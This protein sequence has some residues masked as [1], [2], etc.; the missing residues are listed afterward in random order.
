[1][2]KEFSHEAD[3][4]RYVLRSNGELVSVVDYAISGPS[5][6]FTRTFTSPRAR[7][8]GNAAEVVEFAANDVERNTDLRIVPMCWYV[9]EWFDQH[10]EH[11]HLLTRGL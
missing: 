8:K 9:G 5:I 10:P 1:M 3:A 6:S 4:H 2:S 11:S 7:G